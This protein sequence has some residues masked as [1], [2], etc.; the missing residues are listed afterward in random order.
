MWQTVFIVDDYKYIYGNASC[1]EA[2][3]VAVV[4]GFKSQ[5]EIIPPHC[6]RIIFLIQTTAFTIIHR[7][8]MKVHM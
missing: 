4:N 8:Y 3:K 5:F 6:H 1:G 7:I 2:A